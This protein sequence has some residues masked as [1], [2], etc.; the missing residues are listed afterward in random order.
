MLAQS[1]YAHYDCCHAEKTV[2]LLAFLLKL[3]NR[4]NIVIQ[5]SR[6][7]HLCHQPYTFMVSTIIWSN[8]MSPLETF[9]AFG[10]AATCSVVTLATFWYYLPT[11]TALYCFLTKSSSV[12]SHMDWEFK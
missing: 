3:V 4:I 10:F 9:F 12:P 2:I 5:I 8:A 1:D 7:L 11:L 6:L